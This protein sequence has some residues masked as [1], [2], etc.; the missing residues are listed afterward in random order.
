MTDPLTDIRCGAVIYTP[1]DD[2]DGLLWAFAKELQNQGVIVGGV[3]QDTLR[4]D[5]DNF[6]QMDLVGLQSKRRTKISQNLGS[7]STSCL[8]DTQGVTEASAGIREAIESDAEL[9]MVSKFSGL[10][11]DGLGLHDDLLAAIATGKPVL[12]IVA[13][14]F[15]PAWDMVA[16]GCYQ[17]V[18]P[19]L[20]SMRHWWQSLE[21]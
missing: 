14:R 9:I 18:Q 4:D 7:G 13:K 10:E 3:I 15:Q 12:V 2:P 21:A 5:D 8:V 6:V 19:S 1:D 17:I 11:A 16:E 20:Q